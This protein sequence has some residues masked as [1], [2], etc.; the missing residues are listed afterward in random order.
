M[1]K[2]IKQNNEKLNV[3]EQSQVK[4]ISVDNKLDLSL[5]VLCLQKQEERIRLRDVSVLP[6]A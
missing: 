4:D 6:S 3:I 2:N 1:N 5:E